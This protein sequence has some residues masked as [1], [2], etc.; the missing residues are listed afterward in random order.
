[1]RSTFRLIALFIKLN[2][3]KDFIYRFNGLFYLITSLV[4][5]GTFILALQFILGKIPSIRGF[6]YDQLFVILMLGQLWWFGISILVRKN[7]SHLGEAIN[8]GT[9]DMYLVKPIKIRLVTP[10]L[11]FDFKHVPPAVV[12]L[13]L[14]S[15]KINISVLSVWQILGAIIYFL[16][17]IFII[18]SIVSLFTSFSFWVGRNNAIFDILIELPDLVKLPLEFFP[19]FLQG[20]FIFVFP[21][22]LMINP[23]FQIIYGKTDAFLLIWALVVSFGLCLL[24][25]VIWRQ[26]LKRYVSAN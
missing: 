11:Q 17:G 7:F 4:Y 24:S 2:L 13:I 3:Q 5:I 20:V 12:V 6:G 9:L 18:Y 22:A 25:E 16:N 14:L 23:T 10:F 19:A 8:R 15:T 1:M 26:G 21:I